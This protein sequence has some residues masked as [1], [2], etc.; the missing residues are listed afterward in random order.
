MKLVTSDSVRIVIKLEKLNL[1]E[2]HRPRFDARGS[3]R[4]RK[5]R[6][7]FGA[8]YG[9]GG[10]TFGYSVVFVTYIVKSFPK[11]SRASLLV[12][13]VKLFSLK[14]IHADLA[15]VAKIKTSRWRVQEYKSGLISWFIFLS[16]S[17]ITSRFALVIKILLPAGF[18]TIRLNKQP[19]IFQ[20][21]YPQ[22]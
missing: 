13:G 4:F 7:D 9:G 12:R 15:R 20:G 5:E 6:R 3:N 10:V 14:F 19:L 21:R 8:I 16:S 22:K 18:L 1:F 17:D 2:M 11:E